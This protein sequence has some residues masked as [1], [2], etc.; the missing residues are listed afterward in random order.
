[1]KK[2]KRSKREKTKKIAILIIVVIIVVVIIVAACILYRFHQSREQE[3][4]ED[5]WI[6]VELQYIGSA[7]TDYMK[8]YW[9]GMDDKLWVMTNGELMYTYSEWGGSYEFLD[10]YTDY[11]RRDR[12]YE[13]YDLDFEPQTV[14]E[15]GGYSHY[16]FSPGRK[17]E[18]LQYKPDEISQFGGV[19]NSAGKEWDAE[20]E[21]VVYFYEFEYSGKHHLADVSMEF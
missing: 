5:G 13:F 12:R 20:M 14:L 9:E 8:K 11:Q 10:D 19:L 7:K 6:N 2:S 18:W 3:M 1:M 15:K 17:L 16:V 21:D 4:T